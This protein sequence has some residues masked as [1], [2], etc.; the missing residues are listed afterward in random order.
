[1]NFSDGVTMCILGEFLTGNFPKNDRE[2]LVCLMWS[3]HMLRNVPEG[4]P[5]APTLEESVSYLVSEARKL[6][7]INP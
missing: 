1:M 7:S 6:K 5:P 2:K 3:L 4:R